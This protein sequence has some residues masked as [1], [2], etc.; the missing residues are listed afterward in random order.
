MNFFCSEDD[1]ISNAE[2]E[3]KPSRAGGAE[4]ELAPAA[5][6]RRIR[7]AAPVA[8]TAVSLCAT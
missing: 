4:E 6:L 5:G 8:R 1:I 3:V 7:R 2:T